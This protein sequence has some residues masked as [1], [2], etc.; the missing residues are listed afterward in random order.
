MRRITV[1]CILTATL[2][3]ACASPQVVAPS[4]PPSVTAAP[5]VE[6]S[7]PFRRW[8]TAQV[9]EA[10]KR[11]GLQ[12]DA[13]HPLTEGMYAGAPR[14][15]AEAVRFFVLMGGAECIDRYLYILAFASTPDLETTWRFYYPPDALYG[16]AGQFVYRKD[17]ILI[18]VTPCVPD[19]RAEEYEAALQLLQ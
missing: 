16:G 10:F 17:N 15:A 5:S 6:V 11:A 12:T 9:I 14:L 13:A 4:P 8:T 19:V 18:R 3:A 1:V 7:P 2:L